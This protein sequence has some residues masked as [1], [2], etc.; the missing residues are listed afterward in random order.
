[1]AR[2]VRQ[3]VRCGLQIYPTVHSL[4]QAGQ[5]PFRAVCERKEPAGERRR[6]SPFPNGLRFPSHR[7]VFARRTVAARSRGQ[8]QDGTRGVS[9]VPAEVLS[10]FLAL[11]GNVFARRTVAARSR[12][13]ARYGTRRMPAVHAIKL[14]VI[15]F[16]R[17]RKAWD[18]RFIPN[19]FASRHA[20]TIAL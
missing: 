12:G 3:I 11:V 15:S 16:C 13:Q 19:A 8:A 17:D 18:R 4:R 6:K 2:N 20:K 7:H 14:H 9:A 5:R 1:M 10:L